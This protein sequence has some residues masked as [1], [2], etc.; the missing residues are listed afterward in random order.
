MLTLLAQC[1]HIKP[2]V[3]YFI[4]ESH[5]YISTIREVTNWGQGLGISMVALTSFL[6][7]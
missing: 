7:L 6:K 5:I 1:C 3:G 4:P 2:N